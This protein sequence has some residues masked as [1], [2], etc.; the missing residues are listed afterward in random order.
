[1]IINLFH[2]EP[3]LIADFITLEFAGWDSL[4]EHE[5]KSKPSQRTRPND[6]MLLTRLLSYHRSLGQSTKLR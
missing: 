6:V 4:I 1:M 2:L 3:I 5:I